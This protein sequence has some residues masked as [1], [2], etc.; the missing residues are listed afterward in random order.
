[1]SPVKVSKPNCTVRFDE[2]RSGSKDFDYRFTGKDSKLC[3]QYFMLLI[4]C[5][6]NDVKKGTKTRNN[7]AHICLYMSYLEEL[8]F[9]FHAF[10]NF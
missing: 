9:S 6:E 1:M 2:T 8:C 4:S 3:L 5:L 10:Y 7:S